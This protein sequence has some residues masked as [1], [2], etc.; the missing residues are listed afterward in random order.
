MFQGGGG[1]KLRFHEIREGESG[2]QPFS[3]IY[4]SDIRL[5]EFP[6]GEGETRKKQGGRMTPPPPPNAP[7]L[8]IISIAPT[9]ISLMSVCQRVNLELWFSDAQRVN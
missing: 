9:C 2:I 3:A 8:F 5:D 6:R 1:A 7:L 4:A